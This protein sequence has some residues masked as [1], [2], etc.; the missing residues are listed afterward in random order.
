MKNKRLDF[1]DYMKAWA[2]IVMVEVH[3]VNCFLQPAA[4]LTWWFHIINFING[5]VAPVFIFLSGF[6]FIISTFHKRDQLLS[7]SHTM[8]KRV[9]RILLLFC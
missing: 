3:V 4:K 6:S 8:H 5:L 9:E 1:V 2:M 7:F